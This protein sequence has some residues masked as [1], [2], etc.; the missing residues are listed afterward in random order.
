M[1]ES[2]RAMRDEI[3]WDAY[4]VF[5][6]AVAERQVGGDSLVCEGVED[7]AFSFGVVGG[8]EGFL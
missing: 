7:F 4:C 5:S 2:V 1:D 6:G 8:E 3:G